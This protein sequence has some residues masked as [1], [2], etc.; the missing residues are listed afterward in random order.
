MVFQTSTI[1]LGSST[2]LAKMR[3]TTDVSTAVL[4]LFEPG[5]LNVSVT[6][7]RQISFGVPEISRL[8]RGNVAFRARDYPPITLH[9]SDSIDANIFA[10][11][12]S[13]PKS[14]PRLRLA[15]QRNDVSCKRGMQDRLSVEA[16]D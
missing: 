14:L 3:R 11:T 9:G 8:V 1:S 7:S 16:R 6:K 2:C 12:C 13:N 15:H 10:K 5:M 4:R